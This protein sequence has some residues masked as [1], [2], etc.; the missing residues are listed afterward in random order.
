MG[1]PRL[2]MRGR[3]RRRTSQA[4]LPEQSEHATLRRA[5]PDQSDL[6]SDRFCTV[7]FAQFK[8][9]FAELN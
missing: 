9:G 6:S 3:P 4:G 7:E 1:A 5:P 2:R 8:H